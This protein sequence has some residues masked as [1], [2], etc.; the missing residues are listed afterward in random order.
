MSD[1]RELS[2]RITINDEVRQVMLPFEASEGLEVVVKTFGFKDRTEWCQAF[3]DAH[4]ALTPNK[5]R[6]MKQAVLNEIQIVNNLVKSVGG[7]KAQIHRKTIER[8]L[9]SGFKPGD[10]T[11]MTNS[12]KTRVYDMANEIKAGTLSA[13]VSASPKE[14]LDESLAI[15]ARAKKMY[16]AMNESIKWESLSPV[17]RVM[18]IDAAVTELSTKYIT[19]ADVLTAMRE[20]PGTTLASRKAWSDRR[21]FALVNDNQLRVTNPPGESI[22]WQATSQDL[23]ADDWFLL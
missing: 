6:F 12:G 4:Y 5:K 15:L 10:V 1:Q 3:L 13:P 8:Y 18:W 17:K 23:L 19:F 2:I 9:L 7:D 20:N 22:V 11:K 14:E 21:R 16:D